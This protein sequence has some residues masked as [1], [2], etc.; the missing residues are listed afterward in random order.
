MAFDFELVVLLQDKLNH[1]A[2]DVT[3]I[4]LKISQKYIGKSLGI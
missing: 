3:G 2:C 1:N 4:N